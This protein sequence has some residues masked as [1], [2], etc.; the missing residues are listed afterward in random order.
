M[1]EVGLLILSCSVGVSVMGIVGW[2]L[3]VGDVDIWSLLIFFPNRLVQ[4]VHADPEI[5][6]KGWEGDEIL[7]ESG[8]Q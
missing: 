5:N 7:I 8:K 2:L 3:G 1:Y 4:G 6:L